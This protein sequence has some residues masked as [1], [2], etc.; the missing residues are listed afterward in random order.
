MKLDGSLSRKPYGAGSASVANGVHLT[1]AAAADDEKGL[2]AEALVFLRETVGI[3]PSKLKLTASE[4]RDSPEPWQ[5]LSCLLSQ[6][7]DLFCRAGPEGDALFYKEVEQTK[8]ERVPGGE[9]MREQQSGQ[10]ATATSL[11]ML[12][13]SVPSNLQGVV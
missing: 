5:C 13:A 12:G 8:F 9:P 10:P 2:E 4:A 6:V 1:P 3:P 11:A 7:Y